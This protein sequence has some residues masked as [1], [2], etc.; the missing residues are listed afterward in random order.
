MSTTVTYSSEDVS[1]FVEALGQLTDPRDPRG[2]RHGLAFVV[3]AVVLGILS[4]RSTVS[5]L[6][7]FIRNRLQW[8]REV[9]NQPSAQAISRAHLPRLLAQVDWA[10]LNTLIET[11]FGVQMERNL[12]HEW[13]AIDGKCLRG[14]VGS[15]PCV[16]L[17]VVSRL[18]KR[19][20]R[21]R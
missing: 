12:N 14:T 8:L 11:H 9:T 2:K 21:G 18:T 7:R 15:A 10:E 20:H 16:R 1:S 13:V 3:A 19:C 5:S 4:G 17:S 6:Y